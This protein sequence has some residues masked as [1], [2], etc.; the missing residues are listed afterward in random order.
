MSRFWQMYRRTDHM[1][2]TFGAVTGSSN[3]AVERIP[4]Y[5]PYAFFLDPFATLAATTQTPAKR[6]LYP[7]STPH[8]IF[9][10]TSSEK[11]PLLSVKPGAKCHK[12]SW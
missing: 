2:A 5:L 6:V 1:R 4:R 3:E 8:P 7:T 9:D 11:K 12:K 10:A